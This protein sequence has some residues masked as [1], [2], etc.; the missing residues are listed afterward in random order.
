MASCKNC[1]HFSVC[2]KDRR[3][4]RP[5]EETPP[6]WCKHFINTTDVVQAVRCKNCEHWGGVTHGFVCRKFS[7]IDTK[8]CMGADHFCSYG[9]RKD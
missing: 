7:E 3:R 9:V 8:I 2:R 6:N 5:D 1:V 4:N